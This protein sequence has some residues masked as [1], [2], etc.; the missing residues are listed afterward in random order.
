MNHDNELVEEKE[1]REEIKAEE[2]VNSI[3]ERNG[4][5]V[6]SQDYQQLIEQISG[7]GKY[8]LLKFGAKWCTPCQ[9]MKETVFQDEEVNQY[10]DQHFKSMSIDVDHF[11]GYNLKQ[12]YAVD[13]IPTFVILNAKGEEINR[14]SRSLTT[15]E[16]RNVLSA[17]QY[18]P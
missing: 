1:I 12:Y 15:V 11:D 9:I 10:L 8:A 5:K 4:V 13:Q 18:H 16:M 2:V 3:S 14:Y 17:Y 7:E 6:I